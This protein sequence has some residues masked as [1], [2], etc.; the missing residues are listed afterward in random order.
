MIIRKL[1]RNIK[2][3]RL[4]RF[5]K[6]IKMERVNQPYEDP[7]Y[8]FCKDLEKCL[9]KKGV[10]CE[11]W[12]EGIGIVKAHT[13]TGHRFTLY[14]TVN[15]GGSYPTQ[16]VLV[17]QKDG[18]F[19]VGDIFEVSGEP[20]AFNVI[21]A[22]DWVLNKDVGEGTRKPC[23]KRR[24]EASMSD[25]AD[26]CAAQRYAEVDPEHCSKDEFMSRLKPGDLFVGHQYGLTSY[27]K[28]TGFRG[29]R[30]VLSSIGKKGSGDLVPGVCEPLYMP[31]PSKAGREKGA[32]A[33]PV[34]SYSG[35]E[36]SSRGWSFELWDGKWN[37]HDINGALGF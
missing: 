36:L 19:K 1:N 6:S 2:S 12:I 24:N 18:S 17:Q 22:L 3:P 32:H 21:K 35:C 10:L 11:L 23:R 4:E 14:V 33:M 25:I 26:E 37:F 5:H 13:D 8:E 7:L 29:G 34:E 28:V 20:D 16:Q 27:F 15:T 31:D 30:V 9:E